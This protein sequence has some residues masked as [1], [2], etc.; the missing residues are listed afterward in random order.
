MWTNNTIDIKKELG[1]LKTT[2]KEL[3][4]RLLKIEGVESYYDNLI[5]KN[6]LTIPVPTPKRDNTSLKN[7]LDDDDI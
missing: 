2:K 3:T 7:L 4:E 6:I 5:N 1:V